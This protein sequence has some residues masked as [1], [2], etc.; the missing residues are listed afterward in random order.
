[1]C[2]FDKKCSVCLSYYLRDTSLADGDRRGAGIRE[3]AGL[4]SDM[5]ERGGLRDCTS[6]RETCG[7]KS[8]GRAL[9]N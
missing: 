3:L 1:M 4:R 9:R 8:D 2:Y 5:T 7:G 6:R